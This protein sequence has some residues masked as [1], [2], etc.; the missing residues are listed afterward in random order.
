MPLTL[1]VTKKKVSKVAI[2]LILGALTIVSDTLFFCFLLLSLPQ[3]AYLF[4]A[5]TEGGV[6]NVF[7]TSV[8]NKGIAPAGCLAR[9]ES[10][11]KPTKPNGA[12]KD[13][14][15]ETSI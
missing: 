6:L 8:A 9:L 5:I 11:Q 12:A 10:M 7:D 1:K 2:Y 15:K 14:S 4:L 13:D 3:N